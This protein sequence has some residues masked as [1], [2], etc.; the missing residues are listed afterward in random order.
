[1]FA[2]TETSPIPIHP[3][4][5]PYVVFTDP[6]IYRREQ[7]RIF[8]GPTWH[9]LGLTAELPAPHAYKTT[10][11]GATPVVVTRD[12]SEAIF[13]WVNRCAHRG[14]TIC[15]DLSGEAKRFTCV[16]HQW[17]Y[18]SQG[19]L[20]AVPFRHGIA[21]KGGMPEEFD[22]NDHRPRAMRVEVLDGI[23]F[24]TFAADAPPLLEFLGESAHFYLHRLFERPVEVLGIV[25]QA[26]NCNWKL[27]AENVRDQYHA[28][29]LHLFY[30]I[31]GLNRVSQQGGVALDP[32]GWH[33]VLFAYRDRE[34][35]ADREAVVKSYARSHRAFSLADPSL[36]DTEVEHADGITQQIQSIFPTMVIQQIGN[37]LAIR[38][39][40]PQGPDHFELVWI[41]LGYRDDTPEMRQRRIKQ[42]NLIGPAGF[43]SMEDAEAGELIQRAVAHSGDAASVI[44]MGGREVGDATHRITE[45]AVRGFWQGYRRIME[46]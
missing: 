4:E 3:H 27:Y 44:E 25:R 7:E 46:L 33:H 17:S 2:S 22:F 31:F 45:T 23:I 26:V 21:G 6:E 41:Y 34:D 24:G 10:W 42:A 28:S 9:Y 32:V 38:H 5:V 11:V 29:L 12:D 13:A 8:N 30:H 19:R 40:V 35:P 36:I 15:R 16:Y 14:A 18:D 39:I 37:T 1:M 20:R 43:I